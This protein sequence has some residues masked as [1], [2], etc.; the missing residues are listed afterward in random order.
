VRS[1]SARWESVE[2]QCASCHYI[3]RRGSWLPWRGSHAFLCVR[4]GPEVRRELRALIQGQANRKPD[5]AAAAPLVG[6]GGR[7]GGAV[8]VGAPVKAGANKHG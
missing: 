8:S 4:C 5:Q 7:P 3:T 6:G 1:S 2:H